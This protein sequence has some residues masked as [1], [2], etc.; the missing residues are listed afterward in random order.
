MVR[1]CQVMTFALATA[2][3]AG[4]AMAAGAAAPRAANTVAAGVEV[5][6]THL[7][8]NLRD[9]NTVTNP[10]I[11]PQF[12][13]ATCSCPGWDNGAFANDADSD[14]V[15]S[16]LGGAYEDGIQAADDFYLCEGY[17]YKLNSISA[18][19]ITNSLAGPTTKAK[20]EIYNDC[21]G[22]PSGN[23]I[24]TLTNFTKVDSGA[25]Y[26]MNPDFRLV[27]YTF[28]ING[29]NTDPLNRSIYLK[30]GIYWVS[31]IGLTDGLGC[32][33][34][35][36]DASFW[37]STGPGVKGSVPKKRLGVVG[38]HC[39]NNYRFVN[40]CG[41]DGWLPV[42]DCCFGC[43]DLNFVVCAD[44]CKI[45]IDNGGA[46]SA[47]PAGSPSQFA[48]TNLNA[49]SRSADDFV[50]PPCTSLSI[51]Y[52]EGCV[53]TNCDPRIFTG[54]Y[55]IYGNDCRHPSY[56]FGGTTLC[57]GTATKVVDLLFKLTLPV[58]ITTKSYEAYRLEFHNVNCVLP[59]GAQYW[60]SIGVRYTYSANERAFFCYNFDCRRPNCLIRWNPGMYL[61]PNAIIVPP[62]T[63]PWVSVNH[64]FSFLIAGNLT[65]TGVTS[66][67]GSCAADYNKDGKVSVQDLFD[68]LGSYFA[69]CN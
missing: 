7:P 14:G 31:V 2:L 28:A 23:P 40:D 11:G 64:D 37:G 48:S 47:N 56:T 45:L 58:G 18:T 57:S 69:G 35:M 61:A 5:V 26:M 22:C 38:P 36:F 30:G 62:S 27:T 50:V 17:V 10:V 20:L 32:T 65:T 24:Y 19:M 51:C 6:S 60:I 13:V 46:D 39:D 29:T 53:Y 12:A 49:N 33:M 8:I 21:N 3:V 55:E 1:K 66:G 54:A 16:H 34:Q 15:A 4:G 52:I 25:P 68:F 43:K 63:T 59:G 41:P 9:I 67:T 44:A 42:D